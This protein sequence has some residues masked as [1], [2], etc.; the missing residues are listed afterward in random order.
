MTL[1]L[2]KISQNSLQYAQRTN[3]SN[4]FKSHNNSEKDTLNIESKNNTAGK[5]AIGTATVLA[6]LTAA[7]FIFAKGK[8]FKKIFNIG[9]KKADVKVSP[10]N[11]TPLKDCKL[12]FEKGKAINS[13][14][15]LFS[16]KF[17]TEKTQKDG[18]ITQFVSE[19]EN[20]V[21]QNVKFYESDILVGTKS[22]KYNSNGKIKSI[23]EEPL[24]LDAPKTQLITNFEYGNNGKI[25]S[26]AYDGGFLGGSFEKHFNYGVDGKLQSVEK[27]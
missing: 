19:Y 22:Y 9:A 14:G 8:H 27:I 24:I 13:D 12:K 1:S 17:L 21:L 11:I 6:L 7:D 4:S 2:G 3:Y 5:F 16:G 15:S 26:I 25:K 10:Q 18:N 23:I 20:G